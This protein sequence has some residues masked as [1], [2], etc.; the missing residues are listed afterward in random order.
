MNKEIKTGLLTCVLCKLV[1]CEQVFQFIFYYEC[2]MNYVYVFMNVL[3]KPTWCY[4]LKVDLCCDYMMVKV[5]FDFHFDNPN[6]THLFRS[7]HPT[8]A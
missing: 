6:P 7:H 8:L 3:M 1:A 2:F 4:L 5:L